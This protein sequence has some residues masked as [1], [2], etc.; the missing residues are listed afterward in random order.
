MTLARLDLSLPESFADGVPHEYF[1]A[2]RESSPVSYQPRAEGGGFWSVTRHDDIVAV[3]SDPGRFTSSR[4]LNIVALPE[5]V[6]SAMSGQ[7]LI[8]ND[9]PR[10][11]LLRKIIN[12]GFTPRRVEQLESRVREMARDCIDAVIDRGECDFVEPC[13]YLPVEVIAELLGVPETDRTQLF[14]WTTAI[15]GVEDPECSSPATFSI[16]MME[17]FSYA[18]RLAAKRRAA[19]A[20]DIFSAIAAAEVDG[21]RLTELELGVFFLLLATAGNETTRTLFLQGTLALLDHPAAFAELRA[22]RSLLPGAIEELLRWTSPVH[23]FGRTTTEPVTLGGQAIPAN[24]QVIIWYASANRDPAVFPDPMTFDLRR[25]NAGRHL[26]FGVGP[27]F[28][29][30]ASLARLEARAFFGEV[31]DRVHNLELAGP[32]DR[33]RSN[34]TNGIK[35]M[36]VRFAPA[37][38]IRPASDRPVR[39]A[40]TLD[41]LARPATRPAVPAPAAPARSSLPEDHM[42]SLEL[43]PLATA[44]LEVGAPVFIS[45]GPKGTRVVADITS[46]VWEGERLRATQIGAASADWALIALD[47]TAA[48]DVRTTLET[49]D[50]AIV[51]V[52]YQGR[53]DYS[54]AGAGP[55]YAAPVFETGDERYAWLN[56]VQAIARGTTDG[57]TKLVYDVYEVR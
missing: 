32:V 21:E 48:I 18:R 3:E 20:E 41:N 29:L 14:R 50:G 22:D 53:S 51:F 46:T 13:A 25:D 34:F 54:L 16:A 40:M 47:G 49:D 45:N 10:H 43:I 37:A 4:G 11:T 28:C 12:K 8:W 30:G 6:V 17:L 31:L 52:S 33:L 42:T 27:H 35:R 36:P 44:T 56:K 55:V 9:P 19:P 1:A 7:M 26:A 5:A 23:C 15:F 38:P 2:L 57:L 24:E 39:P